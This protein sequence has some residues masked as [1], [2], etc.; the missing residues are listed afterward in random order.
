MD[1]TTVAVVVGKATAKAIF[2]H[3][4]KDSTLDN[5]SSD[6]IDL[7]AA[8]TSNVL[9]QRKGYRQFEEIADQVS[10]SLLPLFET[11][12]T[13][14]DEGELAT[15]ARAIAITLDKSRLSREILLEHNLQPTQLE[16][17]IRDHGPSD[18]I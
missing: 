6:L 12:G 11:E 16:N 13:H 18:A 17:H 2:K 9:A 10:E 4:V 14:L 3:W 8:K 15:V 5:V 1:L 7:I